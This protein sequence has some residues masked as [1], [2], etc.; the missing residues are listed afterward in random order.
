MT[1]LYDEKKSLLTPNLALLIH[2]VIFPLGVTPK[3]LFFTLLKQYIY[4]KL[5]RRKMVNISLKTQN[6]Q[7]KLVFFS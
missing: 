7:K 3:F 5:I 2:R 6:K 4:L 1:F